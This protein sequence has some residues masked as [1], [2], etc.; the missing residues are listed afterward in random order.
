MWVRECR[1]ESGPTA[2]T[3]KLLVLLMVC[4]AGCD[5][6]QPNAAVAADVRDVEVVFASRERRPQSCF[7]V[8]M[9]RYGE[10]SMTTN[11]S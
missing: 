3:G 11:R 5:D 10:T 8:N 1:A 2:V 4:A 9:T 7:G 6:A